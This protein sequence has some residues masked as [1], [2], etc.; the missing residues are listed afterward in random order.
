M[1]SIFAFQSISVVW[2]VVRKSPIDVFFQTL[3]N[4]DEDFLDFMDKMKVRTNI[5]YCVTQ[6]NPSIIL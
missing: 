5:M 1:Q 6:E 3:P 2:K 4:E